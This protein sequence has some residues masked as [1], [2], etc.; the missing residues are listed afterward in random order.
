M[1]TS[2]DPRALGLAMLVGVASGLGATCFSLTPLRTGFRRRAPWRNALVAAQAACAMTVLAPAGLLAWSMHD[3]RATPLGFDPRGV[4]LASVDLSNAN[5]LREEADRIVRDLLR[6]ARAQAA[7]AAI[8]TDNVIPTVMRTTLDVLPASEAAS[9]R[10]RQISFA[11]VSDGYFE[12]LRIPALGGRTILPSDDRNSRPV[13]VVSESAAKLLWPGEN[14]LGRTLWIRGEPAEREVVGVVR[15]VRY[16]PLGVAEAATPLLFLPLLQQYGRLGGLTLH[17]RPR[18]ELL[19]FVQPLRRIAAGVAK[20]A[21]LYG[22]ETMQ[23]HVENGLAQMRAAAEATAAVSALSLILALAGIFAAIAY[24]VAKRRTEI[25]VR[26]AVGAPAGRV[27]GFVAL[28]GVLIAA[29][30][31][32]AGVAPAAWGAAMLRASIQGAGAP[33]PALFA[34]AAVALTLAAAVAAWAAARRIARIQPA[35]VLRAS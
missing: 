16:R 33:G 15:D 18:G 12:L 21:P 4:L 32:A 17:V 24:E 9:R 23:E 3:L 20:D 35:D 30:G 7:E 19:G 14:P 28:R 26:I 34:L 1:D 22:I 6:E 5:F 13:A 10:W 25:A 31:A 8:T 27:I 11:R 2:L 29:A